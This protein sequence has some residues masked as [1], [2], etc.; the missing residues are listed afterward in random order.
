LGLA[1]SRETGAAMKSMISALDREKVGPGRLFKAA[2]LLALVFM[3]FLGGIFL[4]GAVEYLGLAAVEPDQ[5]TAWDWTLSEMD[6]ILAA[7]GLTFHGW[8]QWKLFSSVSFAFLLCAVGLFLFVR[9]NNDWFVLYLSTSFVLFGTLSSGMGGIV[10]KIY[11]GMEPLLTPLGVFA[12]LVFFMVTF[13]F[14]NGRFV[15]NWTRLAI[16]PIIVGYVVTIVVYQGNQPPPFILFPLLAV[17]TLGPLSQ[18]Y[19]YFKVASSLERQQTKLVILAMAAVI[20][21]LLFLSVLDL[22]QQADNAGKPLTV[23]MLLLGGLDQMI[24]GLIPLSM[25][26]AVLRYRLWDIDLIIRRTLVYAAMTAILGFV[27]FG[28][29]VLLRQVLSALTGESTLAIVLST[30][31]IAALFEPVRRRIQTFIDRRFYRAKYDAAL[32]LEEFS[33]AARQEVEIKHLSN[34]MVRL[35]EKTV[36]P[37][38]VSVWIRDVRN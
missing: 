28:S 23:L 19:R 1:E 27:Y 20:T 10:S 4:V 7:I 37:E 12:W 25:A 32:A 35:V 36:Q 5:F 16:V 31:L 15:P 22:T 21:V 38:Q 24:M 14:P 2:R 30:L 6:T 9:K 13:V 8:L 29:I 3:I 33:T 34:R 18:V 26:M 11:P 17:I